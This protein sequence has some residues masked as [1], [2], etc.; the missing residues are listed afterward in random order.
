MYMFIYICIIKTRIVTSRKCTIDAITVAR[1]S[2]GCLLVL[3]N[4]IKSNIT[5]K[6]V[7]SSGTASNPASVEIA[8]EP[9]SS[10]SFYSHKGR[11][12]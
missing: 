1:L 2:T 8:N 9:R 7:Y 4:S 10:H 6:L 12:R 5:I 3:I 11:Q